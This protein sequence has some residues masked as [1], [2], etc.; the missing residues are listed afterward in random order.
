MYLRAISRIGILLKRSI[1]RY[2]FFKCVTSCFS[3]HKKFRK[4]SKITYYILVCFFIQ[5]FSI[6]KSKNMVN[7]DTVL[8]VNRVISSQTAKNFNKTV[9]YFTWFLQ[10]IIEL[11]SSVKNRKKTVSAAILFC[12]NNSTLSSQVI[13]MVRIYSA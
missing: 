6:N 3:C 13:P 10:F 11:L 4:S 7:A 8:F 5:H 2:A 12:H 1:R 9:K